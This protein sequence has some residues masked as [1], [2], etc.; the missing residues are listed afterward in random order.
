MGVCVNG[1]ARRRS[2]R[3]GH[4]P[5]GGYK[6]RMA[7]VAGALVAVL[8]AAGTPARAAS[9]SW[10]DDALFNVEIENDFFTPRGS[11]QHYTNGVRL[12]VLSRPISG[13]NVPDWS[14]KPYEAWPAFDL[15]ATRRVGFAL[16]QNIY[17]PAGTD[18]RVPDPRDRPYAAWAYLGAILA[19]ERADRL[20]T[21]ELDLGVVGPA[22][23]GREVQNG[24]HKVINVPKANG[25]DH[26]LHNE[27]GIMLSAER[28]W[29]FGAPTVLPAGLEVDAIPI[30]GASAGNVMTY[31]DAGVMLRIGQGLGVD[32]GPPRIRPALPGSP[33]AGAGVNGFGWYLFAGV[34]GRAVVRDLFLDGN[35]FR[36]S[37]SV[38]KKPLVADFEMGF[39]ILIGQ[40]RVTYTYVQRTPE[41]HGQPGPDRFGALSFS[42]RF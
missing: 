4:G 36:T 33:G 17:T 20:D 10:L 1:L 7:L 28:R 40:A 18:Q 19:T 14:R 35:S 27:P 6:R 39:A 16:G 3:A 13:S 29:R 2:G 31:A 21:V 23:G 15:S 24:F 41:F 30:V 9:S 8:C 37:P 26:Q 22:A 42:W 11:D 32:F 12:E 34:D 5:A 25:W 38:D